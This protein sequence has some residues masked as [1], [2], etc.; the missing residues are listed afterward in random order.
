MFAKHLKNKAFAAVIVFLAITILLPVVLPQKAGAVTA[1]DWRAG[2]IIDDV[3]FYNKNSMSA[4]QIQQ[5]LDAKVPVCD[6]N[7]ASSNPSYQPPWTCL[8]EYQENTVTKENN[9]G[10][11]NPNGTPYL[12]PGGKGAA[13]IIWDVAQEY[14]INPQVLIVMLQKEQGL[15]T[16]TWPWNVQYQKAMGYACPDT[17]PCDTQYY[18]FYNQVSSAAWQLKRYIAYPNNYNF[19]AGVS[20]YIQYSPNAACGGSQVFIE[21]PATAALYNYTPYQ[22]NAGALANLYGTADCGAYGNRNFWRYFND[23][24]G[25]VYANCSL[26]SSSAYGIFRLYNKNNGGNLITSDGCEAQAAMKYGY[27][28]D[29]QVFTASS[30]KTKPV[31]RL[32]RNGMYL[33]TSTNTERD[34]AISRYGFRLEGV[35]FYG[36]DP[37][38]NA[39]SALPVYRVSSKNGGYIYTISAQEANKLASEGYRIEGVA[40]YAQENPGNAIVA[41]YRLAHPNGIYLFTTSAAEKDVAAR[42]YGYRIEG[43]GFKAMTGMNAYNL[44][45]Y[46][47]AGSSGYILTNSINERNYAVSIGYRDEGITMYTDKMNSKTVLNPVYRLAGPTGSYLYS[48]SSQEIK[49]ATTRYPY[50]LEGLG[51][52]TPQ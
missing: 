50:K 51:F 5:F 13:Q 15:V 35:A 43:V 26:P 45:L 8:K 23:W 32:E 19:K 10:R 48:S 31:Y 14:G 29:G 16:D 33:L 44:P 27:V 6:R 28:Y 47:L 2:R 9:I 49:D 7:R 52:L 20:R 18:G 22:P 34:A 46:R 39:S 42:S 38:T 12:V 4:Q 30:T 11:F 25:S 37:V 36:V 40:F 24:F 17:A 41:T 1:S 3:V 21:N